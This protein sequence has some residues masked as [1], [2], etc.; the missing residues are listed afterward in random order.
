MP[1]PLSGGQIQLDNM[2][3]KYTVQIL[4]TSWDLLFKF[5]VHVLEIRMRLAHVKNA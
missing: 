1:C 5:I 2:P 3:S 4:P